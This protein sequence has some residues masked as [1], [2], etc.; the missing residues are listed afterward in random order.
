M[1]EDVSA[2]TKAR[3]AFLVLLSY[4]LHEEGLEN[5]SSKKQFGRLLAVFTT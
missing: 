5:E 4:R 1:Y 3:I 2:V